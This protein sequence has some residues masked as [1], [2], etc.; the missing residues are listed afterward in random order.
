MVATESA[1]FGALLQRHRV[2]A[3]MSQ[4]AL[5]ERAGLS[6][7]AISA[8]KRGLRRQPYL[9]TVRML[10]EALRLDAEQRAAIVAAARPEREAAPPR[11]GIPLLPVS[12]T[13]LFGR[14]REVAAVAAWLTAARARLVTLTGPGGVGKTRLALAVADRLQAQFT[15]ME[16]RPRPP[17]RAKGM[18]RSWSSAGISASRPRV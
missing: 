8:L 5:A 11:R 1:P 3:G 13:P 12:A 10:A 17:S 15:D 2:A 16:R 14:E 4:A 7:R 18:G 6:T 9:E